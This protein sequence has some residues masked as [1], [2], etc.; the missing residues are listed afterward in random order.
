MSLDDKFA[1][2]HGM[3]KNLQPY[4]P[5]YAGQV[6]GNPRL[7]IPT[8]SLSDGPAG[9][10]NGAKNV[11]QFPAPIALG[12]TFNRDLAR[13]Y[14]EAIAREGRQKGAHVLLGPGIDVIRDPRWGRSFENFGEDPELVGDLGAEVIQGIQSNHSLATAKHL[15]VYTQE[16]GRNTD[17]SDAR[18]DIRAM[19]EVYLLPYQKAVEANVSSVMCSYNKIN[20][21]HACN[22]SYL[23]RQV[24][25]GQMGF[26][27]FVVSD[28]FGTHASHSSA[29][30]GLDLQM[31]DTCLFEKRLRHALKEGNFST[32]RLDDMVSRILKA[33]FKAKLFEG[34]TI[35]DENAV[36]NRPEHAQL[37]LDIAASGIVLLK[38][39]GN[40]LPLDPEKVRSIAVIGEGAAKK[41][42]SSGGGSAHVIADRVVT[43][44]A[45]ISGRAKKAGI[46]VKYHDGNF[47][48]GAA[49]LAEESD[50]AIV[51]LRRYQTESK[52][53]RH[54]G[55]RHRDRRLIEMVLQRNP[56]TIV[57]LGSGAPLE[58]SFDLGIAGLFMSWYPGEAYGT[59]LAQLIFGD[60]NPAGRLPVTIPKHADD[61]PAADP[62]RFPGGNHSEGLLV[63]YKHYDAHRLEVA[64]PFGFGLSYTNF[65]Y[66]DLKIGAADQQGRIP[67]EFSLQ[68][69]GAREGTAV[70]QLYVDPAKTGDLA[71]RS[72]KDFRAVSLQPGESKRVQLQLSKLDLAYFDKQAQRWFQ[73]ARERQ[74][75]VADSSRDL[76]LHGKIIAPKERWIG[77]AVPPRPADAPVGDA[78][79]QEETGDR[80]HC[81]NSGFM[82]WGLGIASHFGLAEKPAAW[83]KPT[84]EHPQQ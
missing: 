32:Q 80:H 8:L 25:K 36:V 66:S 56:R 69:T 79:A 78:S 42:L 13:Q 43:P 34:K 61:L 45:G 82:A 52:D 23:M 75:W 59:A 41:V 70:A 47:H 76:R 20:G 84:D 64:Y 54:I 10:G 12:A 38:N 6:K 27:G 48:F 31:P 83:E 53:E 2:I 51:V 17:D 33:M 62:D 26:E 28:W 1:M 37:A 60:R 16:T 4:G 39:K 15:A 24:L 55:L 49:D 74:I 65:V 46:R 73:P 35:G 19:H 50:V 11:T 63:G 14:G 71:P 57:V 30:A 72:L 58:P 21:V 29:N 81:P 22:N 5:K 40:I 18:I 77:R 3:A 9:V 67:V 7:C 44:L 68:N